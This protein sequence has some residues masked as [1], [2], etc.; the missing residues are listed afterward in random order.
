[1]E[2]RIDIRKVLITS[3]RVL[4]TCAAVAVAVIGARRLYVHYNLEPWTRDGRVRADVV[5]VSPDVN[6]LVTAVLVQDNQIVRVGQAL[7]VIDRP[8]YELAL[9]Q[10]EAAISSGQAA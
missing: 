9:R 7:F 4:V 1:M 6:G 10:A 8:R 2:L 5:E 3:G